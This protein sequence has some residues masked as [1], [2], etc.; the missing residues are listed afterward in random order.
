MTKTTALDTV[1]ALFKTDAKLTPKQ[2]N[3]AVGRGNYA[4]KHVLYLK[5]AGHDIEATKDG[6]SVV[7]YTYKGINP[8]V[9]VTVKAAD[10]RAKDILVKTPIVAK[11]PSVAKVPAKTPIV[12]K[13]PSVAKTPIVAKKPKVI[14]THDDDI[15]VM[16][17]GRKSSKR[18]D[19]VEATFGSSGSVGSY[20]V[21]ADWDSLDSTNIRHLI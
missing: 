21:D 3:D 13:T 12:A 9:D 4:A 16:D 2:I 19:D 17:R 1:L 6:R 11:T 20:S 8:N 10:R 5:L 15:P 14:V 7:T 18:V